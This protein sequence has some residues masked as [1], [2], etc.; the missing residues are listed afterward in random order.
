MVSHHIKHFLLVQDTN[1]IRISHRAG[2]VTQKQ[3]EAERLAKIEAERL[4]K[5]EADRQ[6][7]EAKN[8]EIEAEE[9]I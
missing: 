2:I 3:V 8:A 6:A 9:D 7:E 5:E 1:I 4:A